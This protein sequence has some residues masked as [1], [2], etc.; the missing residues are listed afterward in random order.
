MASERD[1]IVN[2]L[3]E[4]ILAAY[5]ATVHEG[6]DVYSDCITYANAALATLEADGFKVVRNV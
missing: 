1:E 2:S 5:H 6:N 3:F 4:G